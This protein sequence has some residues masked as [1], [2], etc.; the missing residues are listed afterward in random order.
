M[1]LERVKSG[2]IH[3]IALERRVRLLLTLRCVQHWRSG[4]FAHRW[5]KERIRLEELRAKQLRARE[6]EEV[7]CARAFDPS[8]QP[9][10][11]P[12][13]PPPAPWQPSDDWT[14]GVRLL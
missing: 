8:P 13:A 10:E 2:S 4:T 14:S 5:S 11:K 1:N 3:L 12:A 7:E 9:P 6:Q